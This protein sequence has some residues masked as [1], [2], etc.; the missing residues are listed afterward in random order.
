MSSRPT[1]LYLV[2][3]ARPGG[4]ELY[5]VSLLAALDRRRCEPIVA[6]GEPGPLAERIRALGVRVE[7]VPMRYLIRGARHPARAAGNLVAFGRTLV[8]LARFARAVGA[9]LIHPVDEPA[10]KYG[11]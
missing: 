9:D 8:E 3:H 5:L 6:I 4:A 1:V 11:G 2:F 7:E 10:L